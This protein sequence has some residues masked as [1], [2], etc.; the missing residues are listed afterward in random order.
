MRSAS[1]V[2]VLTFVSLFPGRLFSAST[3]C[4]YFYPAAAKTINTVGGRGSHSWSVCLTPVSKWWRPPTPTLLHFSFQGQLARN[5]SRCLLPVS[6]SLIIT[7]SREWQMKQPVTVCTA[8]NSKDA[9]KG[10]EAYGVE[11][12]AQQVIIRLQ[13]WKN[14]AIKKCANWAIGIEICNCKWIFFKKHTP[15]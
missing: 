5:N 9:R 6:V 1:S 7:P 13:R 8:A 14:R 10:E 2:T 4:G 3:R 15:L 12:A 11:I